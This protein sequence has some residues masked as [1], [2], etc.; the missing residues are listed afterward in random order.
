MI[1]VLY[2]GNQGVFDGIVTSSL[3][4]VKRLEK[5]RK[6]VI[7][8]FTASL[9]RINLKYTPVTL[10]QVKF[11]EKV[12]RNYNSETYVKLYDVTDVYEKEFKNNPNENSSWSPYTLLR[13]LIDLTDL[14]GKILYLDTDVL[15]NKDVSLLYDMNVDGYEFFAAR[16]YYGKIFIN[17]RYIN[18]GV[19]LFNLNKCAETG[20]FFKMRKKINDKKMFFSDQTVLNGLASKKKI[21]SQRFNDQKYLYDSTVIRHFSRRLFYLPY[22]HIANV[23][24]W[25]VD[26]LKK[27]F[28]Y[29][30]F[31]DVLD[32]Y[33][34]LKP[35]ID[36]LSGEK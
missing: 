11:L 3:S 36:K 25:E 12:L 34:L 35:S 14:K 8:V 28:N 5:P 30:E 17:P 27:K 23:K 2:A 22:P 29:S 26:K 31:D 13:L 32:E 21:I 6:V 7:N 24:Q 4:L 9:E 1:N 10:N 15:F 18:A 20:L 16:D 19:I 33:L